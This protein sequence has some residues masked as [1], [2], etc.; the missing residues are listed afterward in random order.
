MDR[1]TTDNSWS[2]KLTWAFSSGE[3]KSTYIQSTSITTGINIDWYSPRQFAFWVLDQNIYPKKW[4][5]FYPTTIDCEW[6]VDFS[7]KITKR[8][9]KVKKIIIAR[10][11][12][13]SKVCQIWKYQISSSG[14]GEFLLHHLPMYF[15]LLWH[16]PMYF[17]TISFTSVFSYHII[18]QSIFFTISLTN[19]FF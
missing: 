15:F 18:Y 10:I 17:L 2:E 12:V 6:M 9:Y 16:I 1:Q 4:N 3:L 13:V 7:N 11:S 14:S 19:V 5:K 8:T